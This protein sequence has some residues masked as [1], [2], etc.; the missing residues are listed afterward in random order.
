[1]TRTLRAAAGALSLVALAATAARAWSLEGPAGALDLGGSVRTLPALAQQP[2]GDPELG[3]FD[4]TLLRLTAR[5]RL[6]ELLTLEVHAVEALT[7]TSGGAAGSGTLLAGAATRYRAL[8]LRWEQSSGERGA[9]ALELDRLSLKLRLPFADLTV[10]RQ[11]INFSKSL[12]WN[13]LDV[14]LPF[15]PR[16]F[17]RDYKPGV[18]ALHL[19]IPLG[20]TS[21]VEVVSALGRTLQPDAKAGAVAVPGGFAA[22]TRTGSA[23]VARAFTTLGRFDLALQGGLVY[24]GWM[25]G[26]GA[27]GEAFGVGLHAEVAATR[28]DAAADGNTPPTLLPDGNGSLRFAPLLEDRLAVSLGVDRRF[29]NGLLVGLELFH[30]GGAAP[31]D[32]LLSAARVAVGALTNLSRDLGALLLK[33]QLTPLLSAQLAALLSLSDRSA[34]F[35]PQLS[36]S[37]SDEAELLCGAQVGL[38]PRPGRDPL[39]KFPVPRSEFGTAPNLVWL[40][41]KLYF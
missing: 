15:D 18:D 36:W 11:P 10:G 31:G 38:G 21:G 3:V 30:D 1:M 12:F 4:Q 24:G 19:I 22:A 6:F 29:D 20:G 14:F 26:A 9:A 25:L 2:H 39:L 33:K 17:D 37:L 8:R 27:S 7:I 32:P 5:A 23:A 28:A 35:V 34:L 41:A 13:P 16:V 40:E